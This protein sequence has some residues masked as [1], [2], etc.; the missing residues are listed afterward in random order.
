M[1]PDYEINETIKETYLKALNVDDRTT[2][3]LKEKLKDKLHLVLDKIMDQ[4]KNVLYHSSKVYENMMEAFDQ[5]NT[6]LYN[7]EQL[8][9]NL[10]DQQ[11]KLIKRKPAKKQ[12]NGDA[13]QEI[14]FKEL[15]KKIEELKKLNKINEDKISL[16]KKSIV[17]FEEKTKEVGDYI[18]KFYVEKRLYLD[19]VNEEKLVELSK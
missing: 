15:D 13:L 12:G 6:E 10:V 19:K 17:E 1:D 8:V 9:E 5:S 7:L 11:K 16:E 4:N 2:E 18:N 14:T 3:T